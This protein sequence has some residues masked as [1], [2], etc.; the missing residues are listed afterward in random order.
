MQICNTVIQYKLAVYYML[1]YACADGMQSDP[2][3]VR[4]LLLFNARS[5]L[6]HTVHR[7]FI[8][9]FHVFLTSLAVHYCRKVLFLHDMFMRTPC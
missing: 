6:F 8:K 5:A 4:I 9:H 2:V 7:I 3:Q 1:E